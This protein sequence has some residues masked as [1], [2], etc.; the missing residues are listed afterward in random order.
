MNIADKIS[1]LEGSYDWS[2]VEQE[3][4]FATR[5][6][7]GIGGS[8]WVNHNDGSIEGKIPNHL[9]AIFKKAGL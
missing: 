9:K 8:I 1:K 4:S 7:F 6:D 2:Y 3:G 5:F